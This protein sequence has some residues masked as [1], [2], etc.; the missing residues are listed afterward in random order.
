MRLQARGIHEQVAH[1]DS[2]VDGIQEVLQRLFIVPTDS[3]KLFDDDMVI[4]SV[5]MSF[6]VSVSVTE[7]VV[8]SKFVSLSM[9]A[10]PYLM[11][12][13][14]ITTTLFMQSTPSTA[15]N[16]AGGGPS[17]GPSIMH[18]LIMIR[19]IAEVMHPSMWGLIRTIMARAPK[20]R[21]GRGEHAPAQP[22]SEPAPQR[23]VAPARSLL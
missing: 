9:V 12:N 23:G 4:V 18:K 17:F 1:E 8:V 10:V 13:K 14:S 22:R 3:F 6:A 19:L 2:H 20:Y 11:T 21:Q 7:M 16:T 15:T 5:S